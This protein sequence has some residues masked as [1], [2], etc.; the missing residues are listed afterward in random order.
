MPVRPRPLL[1]SAAI[2]L[3]SAILVAAPAMAAQTRP[4]AHPSLSAACVP[5]SAVTFSNAQDNAALRDLTSRVA[6]SAPPLSRAELA[7]SPGQLKAEVRR[8]LARLPWTAGPLCSRPA[9]TAL[10]GPLQTQPTVAALPGGRTSGGYSSVGKLFFRSLL[11]ERSCT[12]S[13]INNLKPPKGGTMLILT[14]AHCVTGTVLRLPY[15]DRDFV[16]APDWASN[17]SPYGRWAVRAIYVNDNWLKCPVPG[18]DCHTDPI[19]DYAIMIVR[20]L[21]GRHIGF[22]TGANGV[23]WNQAKSLKSVRI[24][25]YTNGKPRPQ[26]AVTDTTTVT[27]NNQPFR[28]GNASGLGEGTS[29]GPWFTSAVRS[30]SRDSSRGHRRLG[31]GGPNSGNPCYSDFWDDHFYGLVAA[32]SKG[33]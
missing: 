29:G 23:T 28:R 11:G 10:A 19:Y 16:F 21:G 12:A 33:E 6:G 15:A 32:A 3:A 20:P 14:A 30:G 13:V 7:R 2:L 24:V 4:A 18:I 9:S 31:A 8:G 22:I 25:G 27:D 17:K 5:T 26:Y 1:V